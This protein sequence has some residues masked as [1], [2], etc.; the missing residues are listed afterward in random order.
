MNEDLPKQVQSFQ[1]VFDLGYLP[2][3]EIVAKKPN[4][5]RE[6][7]RQVRK[8]N[9]FAKQKRWKNSPETLASINE[10]FESDPYRDWNF[11][12]PEYAN[13][14]WKEGYEGGS[15]DEKIY[16]TAAYYQKQDNSQPYINKFKYDNP[17]YINWEKQTEKQ[18]KDLYDAGYAKAS[19]YLYSVLQNYGPD[20]YNYAYSTIA[21]N[22][23][24]NYK[25]PIQAGYDAAKD[26]REGREKTAPYILGATYGPMLAGA[27]SPAVST[28]A[29]DI[30]GVGAPFWKELGKQTLAGMLGSI[31]ANKGSEVVTGKTLDQNT[32]DWLQKYGVSQANA[33]VISPFLNIGGWASWSATPMSTGV[34]QLGQS[35]SGIGNLMY[36]GSKAGYNYV[37]NGI[38][39]TH[40]QL[41]ALKR[42]DDLIDKISSNVQQ[43]SQDEFALYQQLRDEY[44]RAFDARIKSGRV[45]NKLRKFRIGEYPKLRN[46]DVNFDKALDPRYN[47]NLN[48]FTQN[49]GLFER[50]GV[51]YV[52]DKTILPGYDVTS[53]TI[54]LPKFGTDEVITL[55]IPQ[56]TGKVMAS[57]IVN[58]KYSY[59]P[60]EF[61]DL[62]SSSLPEDYLK[63]LEHNINY[64]KNL[65]PEGSINTFGSTGLVTKLGLPHATGDVD[66]YILKSALDDY[67][68]IHGTLPWKVDGLT[69]TLKLEG[70]K[71]GEM[72]DI[73]LNIIPTKADGTLDFTSTRA[74]NLFRQLHPDEF[75][76]AYMM[77][78]GDLKK[79]YHPMQAQDLLNEISVTNTIMDAFESGKDKHMS[80]AL[81][82]LNKGNPDLVY[83]ALLKHGESFMGTK[84]QHAP[85]NESMFLNK[86][87]NIN[88]LKR[89]NIPGLEDLA[90]IADDPKR[91]KLI[92]EYWWQN[93][94]ILSRGVTDLNAKVGTDKYIQNAL[95][96]LTEWSGGAGGNAWG[97]GLNTVRFGHSGVGGDIYGHIQPKLNG[98]TEGLSPDE[99]ITLVEQNYPTK[100]ISLPNKVTYNGK[101]LLTYGDILNLKENITPIDLQQMTKDWNI[102]G[103]T[104]DPYSSS[105]YVGA[106]S[107][108]DQSR[109]FVTPSTNYVQLSTPTN[110]ARRKLNTR[111][112]ARGYSLNPSK[113]YDSYRD[114]TLD[115]YGPEHWLTHSKL[116]KAYEQATR[117]LD[118]SIKD[119]KLLSPKGIAYRSKRA[120]I[121]KRYQLENKLYYDKLALHNRIRDYKRFAT[122][123]SIPLLGYGAYK[124]GK[125]L[126]NKGTETKE[127]LAK[128]ARKHQHGGL[129]LKCQKGKLIPSRNWDNTLTG[130]LINYSENP[131]SIGWDDRNQRWYAPP[132]NK[133]YDTNQFGMGVDRNQTPGFKDK[134]KVDE[135][136]REYLTAEDERYLRFLAIDAANESANKR[137]EYA[138]KTTGIEGSVSPKNDAITVSAIYNLGSGRV[139]RTIFENLKAMKA[140]FDRNSNVYQQEVH[141]QYKEK[142]RNERIN[143]ELQFFEK[144][145]QQ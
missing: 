100:S 71:Y 58:G 129:I 22:I 141:K 70:G 73:D 145:N 104:G 47:P 99:L 118:S 143:R 11:D 75:Q 97:T 112:K 94:T 120:L 127:E 26:V 79:M 14:S 56:Y 83:P 54:R 64:V 88:L 19:D 140:L 123:L 102:I 12:D 86:E 1:P 101:E 65:F 93:N 23:A 41:T 108:L 78:K 80:R 95:K 27:I 45:I 90:A 36:N 85:V 126:N 60:V 76:Q 74:L 121:S 31:A 50:D 135:K 110:A 17:A 34:K 49:L 8:F 91:M 116:Q 9:K 92:F 33:D 114:N 128:K 117:D 10:A 103:I 124:F 21:D 63:I 81:W 6:Q 69:K 59:N 122:G 119:E 68:K 131:D 16:N 107:P 115:D 109:A 142:K 52:T 72:G 20:G 42:Y 30:V 25:T 144:Y 134:V 87:Q 5:T 43:H 133:G 98:Y 37:K 51:W 136:G 40:K 32:S 89:M 66:T 44:N 106:T 24:N 15:V 57:P 28:F 46:W 138:Q 53:G 13:K 61:K 2:E 7:K 38:N 130:K 132:A 3:V 48:E 82:L 105:I 4:L 35:V 84:M 39:K 113:H 29:S 111:T 55:N 125:H 96:Y 67:E 62:I 18:L 77:A 139:A 137:Y